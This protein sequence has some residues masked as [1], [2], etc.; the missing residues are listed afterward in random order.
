MGQYDK[1]TDSFNGSEAR[2]GADFALVVWE[3]G[4]VARIAVFQAKPVEKKPPSDDSVI[5]L[6]FLAFQ[7]QLP[8]TGLP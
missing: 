7:D 1:S 2:P 4:D 8:D 5:G 6:S 3:S